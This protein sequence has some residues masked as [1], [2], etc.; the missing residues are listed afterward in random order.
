ML[1]E[2]LL[3][4]LSSNVKLTVL[5]HGEKY[6]GNYQKLLGARTYV[7]TLP[8]TD[9]TM[10]TEVQVL[11]LGDDVRFVGLPSEVYVES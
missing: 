6:F 7:A 4:A 9:L 11:E 2:C 10:R 3:V 8:P 1:C 5:G